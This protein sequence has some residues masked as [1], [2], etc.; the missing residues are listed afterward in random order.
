MSVRGENVHVKRRKIG[1]RGCGCYPHVFWRKC[2]Q[3]ALGHGIEGTFAQR[4][5]DGENF[6]GHCL[7]RFRQPIVGLARRTDAFPVLS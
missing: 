2:G 5:A 3:R 7:L 6:Q 1:K 4:P